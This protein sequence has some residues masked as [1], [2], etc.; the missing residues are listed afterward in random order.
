MWPQGEEQLLAGSGVATGSGAADS[1]KGIGRGWQQ[2][3]WTGDLGGV[4]QLPLG[5]AARRGG[6][7]SQ[8]GRSFRRS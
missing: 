8:R 7:R 1:G 3:P 5:V 4:Q 2:L 6:S